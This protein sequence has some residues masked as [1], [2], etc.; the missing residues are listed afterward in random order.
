MLGDSRQQTMG[1]MIDCC[2]QA[3]AG[4]LGLISSL[5]GPARARLEDYPGA[6]IMLDDQGEMF[7]LAPEKWP[8]SHTERAAQ[9]AGLMNK[10]QQRL[11][12]REPAATVHFTCQNG[13]IQSLITVL[14]PQGPYSL[15]LACPV[16]K[17]A[18]LGEWCVDDLSD[19]AFQLWSLR[20]MLGAE[21]RRSDDYLDRLNGISPQGS[22]W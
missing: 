20:F 4:L 17:G 10:F 11:S 19:H 13:S 14:D 9:L 22:E 18:F 5:E 3:A 2:Q 6:I 16:V 21:R 15:R 8:E 7:Y 12:E 1:M